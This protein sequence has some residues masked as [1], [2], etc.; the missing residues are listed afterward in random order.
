MPSRPK[1][2]DTPSS[3]PRTRRTIREED[4]LLG[5]KA[6]NEFFHVPQIPNEFATLIN[7][8]VRNDKFSGILHDHGAISGY[9]SFMR[10]FTTKDVAGL[11]L[12][13][14]ESVTSEYRTC[15]GLACL[16]A[17]YFRENPLDTGENNTIVYADFNE[18]HWREYA[19]EHRRTTLREIIT[20]LGDRLEE[21]RET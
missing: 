10:I 8:A 9:E 2:K 4:D 15:F 21:L 18:E 6:L 11:V 17:R 16:L 12:V 1:K 13:F 20:M 5:A 3:R 19:H 7:T 14:N